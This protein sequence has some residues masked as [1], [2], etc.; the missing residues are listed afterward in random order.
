MTPD[1]VVDIGNSRMKWGRVRG[2]RVAEVASLDLYSENAWLEQATRW[3]LDS[4]SRWVVVSVNPPA[5]AE[6]SPWLGGASATVKVIDSPSQIPLDLSALAERYST[7]ADAL[8]QLRRGARRYT[9]HGV[10]LR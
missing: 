5:T 8:F 10:P 2:N 4:S 9:A 6:F 3:E 7:P 1:V